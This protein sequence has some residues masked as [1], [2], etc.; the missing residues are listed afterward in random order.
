MKIKTNTLGDTFKNPSNVKIVKGSEGSKMYTCSF[1]SQRFSDKI[2][3]HY[4]NAHKDL[5]EGKEILSLPAAKRVKGMPLTEAQ[6]RRLHLIAKL[7]KNGSFNHNT[8]A[9]LTDNIQLE[10]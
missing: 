1:C 4:Y 10:R 8:Q 3:D 5:K 2:T 9:S 7:R 6:T